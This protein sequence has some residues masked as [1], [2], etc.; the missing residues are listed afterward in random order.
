MWSSAITTATATC[1]K[2]SGA[3][4]VDAAGKRLAMSHYGTYA[5]GMAALAQSKDA[6]PDEHCDAAFFGHTHEF[7]EARVGG[8]LVLNP[9]EILGMKGT[10][11]FC[12]YDTDTDLFTKHEVQ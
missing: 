6:S 8:T 4:F 7:C 11:T 12:V 10:P 1:A 2:S 3:H 9:G 5:R